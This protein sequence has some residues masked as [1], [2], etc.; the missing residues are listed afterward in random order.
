MRL[1]VCTIQ[2][3]RAPWLKEWFAFHSLFG[4]EKF[5]FFAHKCTDNTLEVVAELKKSF[6]ISAFSLPDDLPT[7]QLH[8]Y[9]YAYENF[10]HTFDWMAFVDGDEFLFPTVGNDIRSI[11]AQYDYEKLSALAVHWVCFGSNGH[12]QEPQG[13]ITENFRTRPPLDFKDNAHIKS[14]VRGR[15]GSAFRTLSTAHLFQTIFGT[16]DE[17]LRLVTSGKSVHAPSHEH[18]RMN[19]YCCQ[20]YSYFQQFKKNSGAADSNP[21]LIRPDSWWDYYDRNDELDTSL[22]QLMPRLKQKI[23]SI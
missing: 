1:A 20:S 23:D 2:R 18:L 8:A 9:Q 5:F 6:D 7:P 22:V 12:L 15:Q 16:Y 17:K 3:D 21:H 13:L 11:L 14:I 10:N 4:V 19:H